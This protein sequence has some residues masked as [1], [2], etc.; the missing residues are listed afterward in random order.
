MKCIANKETKKSL[1]KER[2][3]NDGKTMNLKDVYLRHMTFNSEGTC[4]QLP[5]A[6]QKQP[7]LFNPLVE[8]LA[9]F[10]NQFTF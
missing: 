10:K 1:M 7:T 3:N 6:G 5:H 8:R 4:S 2:K 9:P